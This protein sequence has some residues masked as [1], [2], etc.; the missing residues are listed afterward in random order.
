MGNILSIKEKQPIDVVL[1]DGAYLGIWGGHAIELG[2]KGKTYELETDIGIKGIGY[3]AVV[4]V[5]DGVAT[6]AEVKN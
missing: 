1:P 3:K 2:F 6:Y 4:T 5:K